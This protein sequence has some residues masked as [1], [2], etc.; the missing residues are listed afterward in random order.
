MLHD[1]QA[2]PPELPQEDTTDQS[3]IIDASIAKDT[4]GDEE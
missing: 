4:G 2:D 1:I 3:D